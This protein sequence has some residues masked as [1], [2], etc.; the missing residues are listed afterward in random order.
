MRKRER[1]SILVTSS[2]L[3]N[4]NG[5]HFNLRSQIL[6]LRNTR[7]KPNDLLTSI[8]SWNLT[9]RHEMSHWVRYHGSTI[10]VL[11]T[12]LR[13]TRDSL[14]DYS[15]HRLDQAELATFQ[16]SRS[17]GCRLFSG[18]QDEIACGFGQELTKLSTQWLSL[19]RTYQILFGEIPLDWS[20]L[21]PAVEAH[22]ISLAL[23]LTWFQREGRG[24]LPCTR[25]GPASVHSIKPL[26]GGEEPVTTRLLFECAAVLDERCMFGT[27][28]PQMMPQSL[29]KMSQVNFDGEYGT[30]YRI[31]QIFSG[32]KLSAVEV[33]ALIDFALNP[34]VPGLSRGV[35]S[36][37]WRELYPPYRFVFAAY[38]MGRSDV[39]VDW[40][41]A[42]NSPS[43]EELQKFF[44][45]VTRRTDLR[46]GSIDSVLSADLSLR[47]AADSQRPFSERIPGM[48]LLYAAKLNEERMRNV[49][50]ISYFGSIMTSADGVRLADPEGKDYPWWFFPP[51]RATD[52]GEFIWPSDRLNIDQATDL[53]L[54]SAFSA[55]YDDVVY[56]TG[57]LS[58]DHL[59][60]GMF[61]DP[62]DF[63]VLNSS[64][65]EIMKIDVAWVQ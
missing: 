6:F 19:Y 47:A 52:A 50:S 48:S 43:P 2:I 39:S 21:D 11:M 36:V 7:E 51:L 4:P 46:I 49:R 8:M 9:H 15:L 29:N 23:D 24:T 14:A 64:I 22:W 25:T 63:G 57:P 42:T 1:R 58:R 10:G 3:H 53:L 62:G 17:A 44:A 38:V 30:P 41:H 28:Y 55:A 37:D 35:A 65:R 33:M 60:A 13:A 54:G 26:L 5:D 56:N 40:E 16:Q 12:L 20:T 34:P 59:P 32:R 45:E 31:A 27:P 61:E 18:E